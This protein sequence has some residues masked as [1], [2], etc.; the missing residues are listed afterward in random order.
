M[1]ES[2]KK[3]EAE[4]VSWIFKIKVRSRK[5]PY[6]DVIKY[7]LEKTLRGSELIQDWEIEEIFE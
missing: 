3:E 1:S 5:T 6:T 4:W 7:D 2:V